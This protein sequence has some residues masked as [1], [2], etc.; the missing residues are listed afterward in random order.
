MKT[1]LHRIAIATL[2]PLI[3]QSTMADPSA[4]Y[5]RTKTEVDVDAID[6]SRKASELIGTDVKNH[7]DEDV[8]DVEDIIVDFKSGEIVAVVI[9]SGGF[10]GMGDTMS[11]V[12]SSSLKYDA[13]KKLLR[14]YLTKEQLEKA[15]HHKAETWDEDRKTMRQRLR[16]FRKSVEDGDKKDGDWKD[17]RS[18]RQDDRASVLSQGNSE[19]D[20]RVT[21]NIRTSV[22]DT[23]MSASAK[24]IRIITRDGKVT[25]RGEVNSDSERS[26]ILEIAKKHAEGSNISNEITVEND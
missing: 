22:M 5:E 3:A 2:I 8:G 11:M 20:L 26:R 7:N 19:F 12:P 10:L 25:L 13:D 15:P 17:D 9:S 24:N 6:D 23:D 1:N 16:D 21:K 18:D 4:T 14:T